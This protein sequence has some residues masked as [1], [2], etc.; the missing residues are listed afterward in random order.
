MT[1]PGTIEPDEDWLDAA[2]HDAARRESYLDDAGF[3]AQVLQRI[4]PPA[5]FSW[6]RWILL[7]FSAIAAAFGLLAFGGGAFIWDA[8]RELVALRSFGPSQLSVLV[9]T[10]LFY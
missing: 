8:M 5:D 10:L 7:G 6:R 3:T 9:F 4:P 2:L 1:G